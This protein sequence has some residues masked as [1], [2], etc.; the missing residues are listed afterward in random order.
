MFN[1]KGNVLS[2]SISFHPS[3]PEQ[4][5]FEAR[6]YN[7]STLLSVFKDTSNH[8]LYIPWLLAAG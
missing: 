1:F 3:K 6:K 4:N 8:D 2:F 5:I 7:M